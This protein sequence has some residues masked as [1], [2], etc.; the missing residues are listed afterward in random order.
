MR[1]DI[2]AY[3]STTRLVRPR[4]RPGTVREPE[5]KMRAGQTSSHESCG[6]RTP[7]RRG[8][9]AT[10]RWAGLRAGDSKCVRTYVRPPAMLRGAL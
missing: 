5:R 4:R 9:P 10:R 6:T 7:V 8:A 2:G 3:R 1:G